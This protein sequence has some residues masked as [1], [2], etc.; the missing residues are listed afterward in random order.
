MRIFLIP[1]TCLITIAGVHSMIRGTVMKISKSSY[2][3][4]LYS[5]AILGVCWANTTFAGNAARH[6][7]QKVKNVRKYRLIAE[8]VGTAKTR[9]GFGSSYMTDAA[10]DEVVEGY[11]NLEVLSAACHGNVTDKGVRRVCQLKKLRVLYLTGNRITNVGLKSLATL[12]NIERLHLRSVGID[13]L[14]LKHLG[15]LKKLQSLRLYR[16]KVTSNGV[17]RLQKQLPNCKIFC[18]PK[19]PAERPSAD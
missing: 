2:G 1:W 3:I 9:R 10:L 8:K 5:L 17:Q 13:D 11:P 16:T 12:K 7:I 15:L 18:Y 4:C 6:E 19:P 14:G